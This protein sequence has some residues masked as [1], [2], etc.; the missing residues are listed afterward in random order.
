MKLPK[1]YLVQPPDIQ[2]TLSELL[3]A[4]GL[5][6]YALS[7]TQKYGHVTY[8]WN[9]NRSSRVDETLEIWQELPSD[10]VPFDQAPDMQARPITKALVEAMESG[11]Y[12]FL[13]CNYP[14]G[15]MVG[16]T[17]VFPAVLQAMETLDDC[18]GQV[19]Q[20]A[21]EL[22]YTLLITADH[23]NADQ[24]LDTDKKGNVSVRT[25][26]SLNPVPFILVD[27]D[28]AGAGLRQG[29]GLANVAATVAELL[30]LPVPAAWEPS[31]LEQLT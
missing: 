6:S 19:V 4:H 28:L 26:H 13:R 10:T 20:A 21:G 1:R 23:G 29:G 24:M 12:Q 7:E 9:G 22:G 3:A 5:R 11:R 2:N 14:N 25:A 31:L 15:D 18:I 16:H 8:F 27:Q 30:E 17:G